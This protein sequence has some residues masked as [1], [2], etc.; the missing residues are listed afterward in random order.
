MEVVTVVVVVVVECLLLFA[1]ML[2]G[3]LPVLPWARC[4]A[5]PS[6]LYFLDFCCSP[7]TP[8]V[9]SVL[10]LLRALA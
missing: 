10:R 8:A 7:S 1:I 5:W 3:G 9:V 6:L 4:V 2:K